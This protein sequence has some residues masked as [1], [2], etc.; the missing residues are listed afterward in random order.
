M[1]SVSKVLRRRRSLILAQGCF[2]PGVK[3]LDLQSNSE[4]VR[5]TSLCYQL[6][7]TFGVRILSSLCKPR[8]GN[9]GLKFANTFGVMYLG[10]QPQPLPRF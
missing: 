9:P 2:N 6:A 5:Y 7:N 8:V 4:G 1:D 3:S 10:F